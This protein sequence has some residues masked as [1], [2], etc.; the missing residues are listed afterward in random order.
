[1]V[2]HTFGFYLHKRRHIPYNLRGE[3]VLVVGDPKDDSDLIN[4]KY[5]YNRT[6]CKNSLGHFDAK[7]SKINNVKAPS[8]PQDCVN[9]EY[10]DTLI[11]FD[12][13]LINGSETFSVNNKRIIDVARPTKLKDAVNL[14]YLRDFSLIH[15]GESYNANNKR[16]ENV[17]PPKNLKDAINFEFFSTEM[18]NYIGRYALIFDTEMNKFSAKNKKISDVSDPTNDKDV[19]T[20]GYLKKKLNIQ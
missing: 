10:V 17:L 14:R 12:Q 20:L 2:L 9:K 16:I 5:L 18:A 6:L 3:R 7:D 1:M 15:D 11:K 19:V 4:K 8:E 13:K